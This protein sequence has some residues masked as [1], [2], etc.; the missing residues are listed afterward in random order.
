MTASSPRRAAPAAL[1]RTS[2]G[3]DAHAC[4]FASFWQAG[5]E[6][7]DHI[8]GS[9][10]P[11]SM[12]MST[13]HLRYA[14]HDY[15]R[16]A[17]LGIRT[18]RESA[19]WR[20]CTASEPH[21]FASVGYRELCARREGVQI[22]WSLLHYGVPSGLDVFDD[23]LI[24]RFADYCDAFA[25]YLAPF[26]R[27][28][29]PPVY[30]PVN[31][32][33]FMAWAACETGLLHPHVGD[34]CAEGYELKKRLVRA[35]L[36]GCDAILSRE[37]RARFLSVDPLIHVVADDPAMQADAEARNAY[38]FQAWDMLAGALEPQLGGGPRYLDLV[39]VNYYPHNQWLA[40]SLATLQWPSDPRRRPLSDMLVEIHARY[41]RPVVV[42]ETSHVG[43]ARGDWLR[44][45]ADEA[46]QARARG[47]RI[48]GICLYPAVDRPDWEQ[49]DQ[50]HASGLWHVDP[51]HFQRRLVTPYADAL[52][53]ARDTIDASR[54][55]VSD[56]VDACSGEQ[57]NIEADQEHSQD[58]G[59]KADHGC[60][61]NTN[62]VHADNA[63]SHPIDGRDASVRGVHAPDADT[64]DC[65]A[66]KTAANDADTPKACVSTSPC[67][68]ASPHVATAT[69]T[70]A[71]A[72]TP[73]EGAA[74][75]P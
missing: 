32:I 34:R 70:P 58:V 64:G 15:R 44:H 71:A 60:G 75:I 31:E 7:A 47:A 49:P 25:H 56:V 17:E 51:D 10:Q 30:T 26:H 14:R 29:P 45:V 72:A 73:L 41:R 20:L 35:A 9:A 50:W 5:F 13:G 12:A 33:S 36:A 67:A 38:Q 57:R 66:D 54:H 39:G 37:P 23:S 42:S 4:P 22:A 65:V 11:L 61:V 48:D 43:E 27:D 18:V 19:G 16:L 40:R 69:A 63:V 2:V 52:R 53:V 8:N 74:W 24:E 6:G 55:T 46:A 28:G 62:A 59:A 3:D 68:T 1:P 21:D